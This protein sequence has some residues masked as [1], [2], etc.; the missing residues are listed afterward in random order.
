MVCLFEMFEHIFYKLQLNI[1]INTWKMHVNN[2]L[3][4]VSF[5]YFLL[6][7]KTKK[8]DLFIKYRIYNLILS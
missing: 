2:L 5:L 6:N 3:S 1:P 8:V 7:K 4:P